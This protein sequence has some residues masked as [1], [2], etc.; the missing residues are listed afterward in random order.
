MSDN[1]IHT[2]AMFCARSASRC[3]ADNSC[4]ICS[5]DNMVQSEPVKQKRKNFQKKLD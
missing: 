4:S 3:K 5:M 2:F 1:D